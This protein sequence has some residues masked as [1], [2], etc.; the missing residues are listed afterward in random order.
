[1]GILDQLS[2]LNVLDVNT[3]FFFIL[4]I[5]MWILVGLFFFFG[6]AFLIRYVRQRKEHR[7]D[8]F[9]LRGGKPFYLG[10]DKVGIKRV[11]GVD[12]AVFDKF[13]RRAE[14]KN[15]KFPGSN[16]QHHFKKG[17]SKMFAT[18]QD[19]QLIWS[20]M[21]YSSNPGLKLNP[22][23][24]D[25]KQDY[26][27]QMELNE[28]IYGNDS[29]LKSH[30]PMVALAAVILANIIFMFF[31]WQTSQGNQ[32]VAIDAAHALRDAVNRLAEGGFAVPPAP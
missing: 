21:E 16:V 8:V 17:A 30:W 3:A 4:T 10:E 24:G 13:K 2:N 15:I 5:V 11:A 19:G 7:V 22:M 26:M 18:L 32:Q 29:W 23:P 31:Q 6:T 27:H 9:E 25:Q 14:F 28:L 12:M 1:M 20:A